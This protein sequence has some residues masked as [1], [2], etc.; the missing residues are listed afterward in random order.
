M[1]DRT[2]GRGIIAYGAYV[3]YWRLDRSK[4]TASMGSGGGRGHRAVASYDE[5]TTTMGVE[6]ARNALRGTNLVPGS[7]IFATANPAYLDKTNATAIH[8]ALDLP[9]E[10]WAVDI[11]GSP[12]SSEAAWSVASLRSGVNLGIAADLRTGRPTSGDEA[13]GGDGA[14]AFVFGDDEA[15]PVLCSWLGGAQASAEFLD[16]YRQPGDL[17]SRIWE[18]RFGEQVYVPLANDT[19]ERALKHANLGLDGIDKVAIVGMH[20]RAV[21]SLSRLAGDKLVSDLVDEIGNTGTAHPALVLASVLDE[22]EPNQTILLVHLADGCT[23]DVLRTTDAIADHTPF[24][25]VRAQIERGNDALD[26]SKFLTWRGY[27]DREP[28]RRPDPDRP[29]APPAFRAEEWKYALVGSRDRSSGAIHMPPMRVSMEGGA[30]DDMERI[31]MADTPATIATFTVDRLA[32]SLS[33][34]VV[35]VV[36]DYDGGGRFQAEMTDV[37]PDDVRIGD[38]VEMTFRRLYTAEGIHNYFWKARPAAG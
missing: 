27:L 6:A 29:G 30:V 10:A 7:V 37:D 22:A 18:E 36:I 17:Y 4:I 19:V 33:P 24:A 5:D 35:A 1:G 25:P 3:P 34:P 32:Y 2:M 26:Y 11:G 12:R 16:R 38:R 9:S 8:A 20:A 28:P 31:R 23:V 13:N 14:A 21:R 15:S